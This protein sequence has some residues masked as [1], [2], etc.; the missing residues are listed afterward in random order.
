MVWRCWSCKAE[1]VSL[2][3]SFDDPELKPGNLLGAG[4]SVV[5]DTVMNCPI[6]G[7]YNVL[8]PAGRQASIH[9]EEV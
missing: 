6:C 4:I 2:P 9:E 5:G 3:G 8:K 7:K 1:L